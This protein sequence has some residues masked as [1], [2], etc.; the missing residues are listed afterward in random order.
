[1][2]RKTDRAGRKRQRKVNTR[3]QSFERMLIITEGTNTEIA[4]FTSIKEH[5][6]ERFKENL[7]VD[8]I[9]IDLK[10]TGRGTMEV[11]NHARKSKNRHT[12]SDVWIV[13]DKDDFPD[14]DDAIKA[15][16]REDFSVAWSNQSFELWYLLHFQDVAT[17]M[18]NR[19]LTE[20][21]SVHL[22]RAGII[23]G[24]YSKTFPISYDDLKANVHVAVGRSEKLMERYREDKKALESKMNPATT[25]HELVGKL[26]PYLE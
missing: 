26:L 10:G 16:T 18:D 17:S 13:F 12:Y 8:K 3:E 2:M 7:I 15:A 20:K 21:L 25:V 6:Q 9:D 11:V 23:A 5:I 24:G 1:M 14:F 22:Q 19:A 4:Y